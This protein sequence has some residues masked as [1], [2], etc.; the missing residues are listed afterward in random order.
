MQHV[1]R[2]IGDISW[3]GQANGL[4]P[5][6][7]AYIIYDGDDHAAI[8]N[9]IEAQAGAFLRIQAMAVQRDQGQ[10][11]DLRQIPQ[12]RMLVP[13]KWIVRITTTVTPLIGELPEADNE[14]VER[15]KSGEE[16]LKQ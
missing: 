2:F 5:Q 9:H 15:L 10:V 8:N 4:P 14:G 11:I 6:I 16:P 13:M 3:E 12:D 7:F 1:I